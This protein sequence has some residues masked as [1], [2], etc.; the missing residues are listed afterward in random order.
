MVVDRLGSGARSWYL[1]AFPCVM[2]KNGRNGNC[3]IVSGDA[4]ESRVEVVEGGY[5]QIGARGYIIVSKTKI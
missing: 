5:P 1:S 3:N 4:R 2:L